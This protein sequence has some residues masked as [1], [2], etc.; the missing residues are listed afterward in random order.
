MGWDPGSEM[1]D[2]GS[3]KNLFRIPDPWVKKAPKP[4]SRIRS[5]NAAG[6]YSIAWRLSANN[7][8]ISIYYLN[9]TV[10]IPCRLPFP[11]SI[12][13][14]ISFLTKG[15]FCNKSFQ[16]KFFSFVVTFREKYPCGSRKNQVFGVSA[17][18]RIKRIPDLNF[19][20]PGSR[21]CIKEFKYNTQKICF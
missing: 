12:V 17:M 1:Q 5:R 4:G 8:L 10:T 19:F 15:N 16:C 20:H 14:N 21:I 18:L 7:I 3:G 9:R 13:C 2:P 11:F 6:T